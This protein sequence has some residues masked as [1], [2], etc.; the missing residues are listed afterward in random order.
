LLVAFTILTV[1]F[2]WVF[3]VPV[4]YGVFIK[5]FGWTHAEAVAGGSIVLLLIGLLG[6]IVGRL[7]DRFTPKAVILF[8]LSVSAAALALL[9]TTRNLTEF[10]SFCVLLGIGS[11]SVS[12][13]PCSM[14]IAPWFSR[15]RGLAVGVINSGV[16]VGG[17]FAPNLTRKFIDLYGTSGA[18]LALAAAVSVPFLL[19]LLLVR[20]QRP[21]KER[22][23]PPSTI[24]FAKT[25][26][27]WMLGVGLFFA[28]HTLTGVQQSL[29]L[30]LTGQGVAAATATL[31]YSV[32]LGSSAPGKLLGGLLSDR[33]S[34]RVSLLVSILCLA[35]A[36]T[37]LLLSDPKAAA[38]FAIA[39][40]FGLGYGGVF[41]APSIIA[42]EAVGTEGVGTVLGLFMMFFGLGTSS[43]GLVAGAIFDQTHRY[44]VSF[45]VDLASCTVGFLLLFAA[46][47]L[48]EF[49]PAPLETLLGKKAL[50]KTA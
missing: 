49:R 5:K 24:W 44:A 11:A 7:A 8:G 36:I 35:A 4:F 14:L 48:R 18:F 6:P 26:V 12:L 46:G 47:W 21:G 45:S 29:I 34:A 41:N 27:F 17:L 15:S 38:I 20:R 19:T 16:G 28:A 39:A 33:F 1:A 2:S 31:A 10:L 32:L 43:G 22:T 37:G 23:A 50:R 3:S 42:F 25:L 13:V 30:Y 9:S 40:V